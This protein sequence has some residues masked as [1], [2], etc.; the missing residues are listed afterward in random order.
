[1]TTTEQ[2]TLTGY[3]MTKLVNLA[4]DEAGFKEIPP[5]MVYSYIQ[6]GYIPSIVVGTQKRVTETDVE[7]W[8]ENH[9]AKKVAKLEKASEPTEEA[10]ELVD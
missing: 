10:E 8:I 1:M 7:I 3:A 9:V 2:T 4:L 6:K 5:Q